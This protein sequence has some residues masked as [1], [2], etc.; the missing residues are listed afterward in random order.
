MKKWMV[1]DKGKRGR[2][3]LLRRVGIEKR[4][5]LRVVWKN[6]IG[7]KRKGIE[8]IVDRDREADMDADI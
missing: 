4:L 7:K 2:R 1:G 3:I 6:V 5:K 8:K